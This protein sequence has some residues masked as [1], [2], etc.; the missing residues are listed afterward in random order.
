[1]M[2]MR[3]MRMGMRM[4]RRSRRRMTMVV[5]V[6]LVMMVVKTWTCWKCVCIYIYLY[7]YI[8]LSIYIYIYV[9]VYRLAAAL[10]KEPFAGAFWENH[11]TRWK[12][13]GLR[14]SESPRPWKAYLPPPTRLL[15]IRLA[16]QEMDQSPPRIRIR[17]SVSKRSKDVQ[18]ESKVSET[19]VRL[20]SHG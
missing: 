17:K 15:R 13:H 18:S 2:M 20:V 6:V 10:W 12:N 4:R 3:M 7:I 11:K 9:Y 16:L 5:V 8:Y 1:M 14:V 19:V